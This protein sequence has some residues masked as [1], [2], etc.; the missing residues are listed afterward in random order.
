MT[1]L[2]RHEEILNIVIYTYKK[3]ID[4]N[5]ICYLNVFLKTFYLNHVHTSFYELKNLRK[6]NKDKRLHEWLKLMIMRKAQLQEEELNVKAF[7][8]DK[9]LEVENIFANYKQLIFETAVIVESFWANLAKK[10][11]IMQEQIGI[12]SRIVDNYLSIKKKYDT[13]MKKKTDFKEAVRIFIHFNQDVMNFKIEAMQAMNL[14]KNINQKIIIAR[15]SQYQ[16]Q[17][18]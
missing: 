5:R 3:N 15:F 9:T 13:I 7:D 2:K 11:F 10:E 12:G 17:K 14:L 1:P 4:S 8:I 18:E 6:K 16:A